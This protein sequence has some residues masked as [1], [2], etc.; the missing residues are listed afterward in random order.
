MGGRA[1]FR[2]TI[3]DQ[4]G[5]ALSGATVTVYNEGT[6]TPISVIMYGTDATGVILANP[7]TS[8]ADGVVEFYIDTPQDVDLKIEKI[9]YDTRTI[10]HLA[11]GT[12]AIVGFPSIQN[13]VVGG[14]SVAGISSLPAPSDHV[15]GL[16]P[17]F[18]SFPSTSLPGDSNSPGVG[19]SFASGGHKH[20]REPFAAPVAS[21]PGDTQSSGALTAVS[22]SDHR[23]AREAFVTTPAALA[24]NAAAAAGA[25]ST[26]PRGD[27]THDTVALPYGI[28]RPASAISIVNTAATST[29]LTISVPANS[30]NGRSIRGK[31]VGYLINNSGASQKLR[32]GIMIDATTVM[33]VTTPNIASTV[34]QLAVVG[35][36]LL[37]IGPDGT[38]F[39]ASLELSIGASSSAGFG[40]ATGTTTTAAD[41]A[42]QTVTLLRSTLVPFTSTR[43]FNLT[44]R[45]LAGDPNL[46]TE[47][48]TNGV[49]VV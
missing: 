43:S 3:I 6:T 36:F 38:I 12:G 22:H 9:G 16:P 21:A 2:E 41:T 7:L 49:E 46:S 4:F 17:D 5:N 28:A 10:A 15:H 24:Q 11:V 33:D 44:A 27:H 13:I 25:A 30:L 42:R 40:A 18:T 8:N 1:H 39:D 34:F 23:H 31:V 20:A 29:L 47:L 35:T 45:F 26:V 14:L 19:T 32:I 37:Q 48:V